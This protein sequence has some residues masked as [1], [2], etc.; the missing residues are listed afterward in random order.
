[1]SATSLPRKR[2][3]HMGTQKRAWLY[4]RI[5]RGSHRQFLDCQ[6]EYLRCWAEAH[7]YVVTGETCEIKSGAYPDRPGL[8]Q[9]AAAASEKRMDVLVVKNLS[10]LCRSPLDAYSYIVLL[11]QENVVLLSATE[12]PVFKLP[13]FA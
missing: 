4:G 7:G 8:K 6:M 11:Q 2:G 12:G 10:R 1:M 3:E 13:P 5:D 9:I